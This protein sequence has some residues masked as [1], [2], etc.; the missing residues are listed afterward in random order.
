MPQKRP[1]DLGGD[2]MNAENAKPELCASRGRR[3]RKAK[4]YGTW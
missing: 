3:D 4:R 1:L 2:T